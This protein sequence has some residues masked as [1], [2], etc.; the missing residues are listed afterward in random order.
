MP[1]ALTIV[2]ATPTSECHACRQ[3]TSQ[4]MFSLCTSYFRKTVFPWNIICGKKIEYENK[5]CGKNGFTNERLLFIVRIE[6]SVKWKIADSPKSVG[7]IKPSSRLQWSA[8]STTCS[9]LFTFL[10]S[11][12]QTI[13]RLYLSTTRSYSTL[14]QSW[15]RQK[16]KCENTTRLGVNV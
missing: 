16:F 7:A 15:N 1:P 13:Q 10:C 8:S 12:A 5:F 9:D 3:F 2:R 4:K 11:F 14:R 6:S